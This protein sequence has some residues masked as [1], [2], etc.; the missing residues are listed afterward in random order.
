MGASLCANVYIKWSYLLSSKSAVIEAPMNLQA[1]V[2]SATSIEITWNQS[3]N[4]TTIHNGISYEI[5]LEA[6]DG[7]EYQPRKDSFQ[8]PNQH[9]TVQNL[10]PFSGYLL[11][12]TSVDQTGA[13][14]ETAE[15]KAMTFSAGGLFYMHFMCNP[16][17]MISFGNC[18][19]CDAMYCGYTNFPHYQP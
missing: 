8:T 16:F 10:H 4:K 15:V 5:T 19:G 3:G 7:S 12:V 14:S 1:N 9:F 13:R 17:K 18:K 2:L 11:S 6:T